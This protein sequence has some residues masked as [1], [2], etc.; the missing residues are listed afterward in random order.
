MQLT[1]IRES[2]VGLSGCWRVTRGQP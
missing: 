1:R 2:G